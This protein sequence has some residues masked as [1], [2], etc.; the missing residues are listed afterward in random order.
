MSD[1]IIAA[2]ALLAFL[3]ILIFIH[4]VRLRR[5]WKRMNRRM[6]EY[7]EKHQEGIW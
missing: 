5:A 3:G 7:L 4:K 2:A 1:L 6:D